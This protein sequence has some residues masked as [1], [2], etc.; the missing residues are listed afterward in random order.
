MADQDF[1][2]FAEPA[3]FLVEALFPDVAEVL[4][5]CVELAEEAGGR[6]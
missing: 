1:G 2:R 3:P 6:A 4:E 5:R